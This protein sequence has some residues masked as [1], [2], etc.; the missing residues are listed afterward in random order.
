M[1]KAD[2]LL[3]QLRGVATMKPGLVIPRMTVT[4]PKA[5]GGLT[6]LNKLYKEGTTV[7]L[8]GDVNL[9]TRDFVL[10]VEVQGS[11]GFDG[12]SIV[13]I[14]ANN[15]TVQVKRESKALKIPSPST[16]HLTWG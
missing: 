16:L 1:T 15:V 3:A 7:A 4:L 5:K 14:Q 9:Q 11:V 13:N 2:N 10:N 8:H 6:F 12:G